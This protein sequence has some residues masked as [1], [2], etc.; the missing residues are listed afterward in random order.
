MVDKDPLFAGIAASGALVR[1]GHYVYASGRHG[2]AYFDKAA[3]IASP[4]LLRQSAAKIAFALLGMNAD[5]VVGPQTQC[6][7]LTQEVGRYLGAFANRAMLNF[8][9]EKKEQG[10]F[11]FGAD[12]ALLIRGRR[13]L[14]VDDVVTTGGTII[15]VARFV[16]TLGGTVVGVGVMVNRGGVRSLDIEG[17]PR[18]YAAL[19]LD[20][21]SWQV[22]DCPLCAE[23]VPINTD[24][25]HG[26]EFLAGRTSR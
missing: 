9:A 14:V 18:F 3:V 16:R 5:G 10:E 24:L 19:E 20:L 2:R 8:C 26:K 7:G 1:N 17:K 12:Q 23:S 22:T 6:A 25:G 15:R 13:F 21:E 11:E 4:A